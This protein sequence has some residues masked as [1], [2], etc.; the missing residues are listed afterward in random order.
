M[1]GSLTAIEYNS[2]HTLI[3]IIFYIIRV[4]ELLL[5]IYNS[6]CLKLM[7]ASSHPRLIYREPPSIA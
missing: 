6:S 4:I 2:T 3:F 5:K 7:F 1:R